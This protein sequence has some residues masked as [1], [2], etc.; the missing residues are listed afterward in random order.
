MKKLLIVIDMQND[1]VDGVLG[2]DEAQEIVPKIVEKIRNW[3]GDIMFT[4]DTHYEDYLQTREGCN[5]VIPHCIKGTEG[6][7][8]NPQIET[9]AQE[10]KMQNP[11]HN[12]ITK[13]KNYFGEFELLIGVP[14]L[15]NEIE[16]VGVCTDICVISNAIIAKA[17]R[18][19][20]YIWVDASCCAGTTPEMHNK[21]L[22]VM[23]S[24]QIGVVYG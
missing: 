2:T 7:K 23:R 13:E 20:A 14:A 24:C 15:Y 1:F 17:Y 22:D 18:P 19:E 8:L 4:K 21:A 9:A 16:F 11:A 3:D 12:I 5:L 10:Y 6:H